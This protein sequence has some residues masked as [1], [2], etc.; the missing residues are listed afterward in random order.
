LQAEEL[1][2]QGVHVPMRMTL[3]GSSTSLMTHQLLAVTG[4]R[5]VNQLSLQ[6]GSEPNVASASAAPKRTRAGQA[7]PGQEQGSATP[8]QEQHLAQEHSIQA[9]TAAL[10][11]IIGGATPPD[12]TLADVVNIVSAATF[13]M[14]D[15]V[16]DALPEDV[17]PLVA[18]ADL[19]D[20]GSL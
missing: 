18:T 16:L 7:A 2:A 9:G 5:F 20:A 8:E 13:C 17:E 11:A 15:C 1:E 12:V 6:P 3:P 4:K 14:A 19:D 10:A